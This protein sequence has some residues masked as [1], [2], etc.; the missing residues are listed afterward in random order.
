MRLEDGTLS[1][2]PCF[3]NYFPPFFN[4]SP[5]LALYHNVGMC[6]ARPAPVPSLYPASSRAGASQQTLHQWGRN[7]KRGEA[8]RQVREGEWVGG[9]G[10]MNESYSYEFS[11]TGIRIPNWEVWGSGRG[12]AERNG[13]TLLAAWKMFQMQKHGSGTTAATSHCWWPMFLARSFSQCLSTSLVLSFFLF[14]FLHSW[15]AFKGI[16]FFLHTQFPLTFPLVAV[17]ICLCW[18]MGKRTWAS[19]E[20]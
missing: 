14:F 6:L 4:L 12:W 3:F 20:N 17:L 16:H 13:G 2:P 10:G 5:P 1:F 8:G 9:E 19:I 7:R 11:F 18:E 15:F